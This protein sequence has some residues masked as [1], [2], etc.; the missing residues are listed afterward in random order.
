MTDTAI[1]PRKNSRQSEVPA[2]LID[3]QLASQVTS[4]RSVTP[5]S[6]HR[7]V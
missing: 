4:E 1:V 3:E 7:Y 5:T 6:G 2:P